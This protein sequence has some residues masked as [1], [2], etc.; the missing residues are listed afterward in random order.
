MNH[1]FDIHI[2]WEG[3]FSYKDALTQKSEKDYGIYQ[4]YGWHPVY[5]SDVLLYIGKAD[6][7]HFGV[8]L[9]QETWWPLMPDAQRTSVYLGRFAGVITPADKKW[10]SMITKAE[11]LLIFAHAPAHNARK[12]I[13]SIDP[14]L[15]DV[16]IY[17]WGLHRDLLPELSGSRWTT[18]LGDMPGYHV[19]DTADMREEEGE[20]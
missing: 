7:Q 14:D 17:N 15:H 13:Q 10:G 3:P 1:E 16:H 18:R 2:E 5:G 12:S 8:R 11:R 20:Q 19:F 6:H 9:G 4:I